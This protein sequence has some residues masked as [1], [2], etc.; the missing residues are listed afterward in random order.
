MWTQCE[1]EGNKYLL[2]KSIIE[3]KT[4][5]HAVQKV[6]GFTYLNERKHRKKSTK[7]WHLC[8]QWKDG[9][10]SWEQLAGINESNPVKVA[11]Y[12]KARE[13]DDEPAFLT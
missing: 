10:T 6:D 12:T 7:G 11:K 5:G 2:M 9:S 4:D 3:D 8:I 13:I 1:V